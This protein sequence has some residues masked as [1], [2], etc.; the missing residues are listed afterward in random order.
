[1]GAIINVE[2]F[3]IVAKRF[4]PPNAWTYYFS[5][6]DDE[7]S[8]ELNRK[9]FQRVYLRPR[10]LRSVE[11][12]DTR[13]TILGQKSSLPIFVSSAAMAKFAH[14]NGECTIAS[15][16]SK[17][18]VIQVVSTS[19]SMSIED[20]M[21]ARVS[22]EQPVFFQLYVNRDMDKSKALIRRAEKAGVKAIWI[23]VD[24]PVIG[25][26]KKDE[27]LK[28]EVNVGAV[29]RSDLGLSQVGENSGGISQ[30]QQVA[31]IARTMS[32]IITPRLNWEDLSWIRET[33][34]LPLVIKGIQCVEDALLAF[35]HL[36]QGIVL[37]NH[38]GRS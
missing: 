33:T 13:T 30:G 5:G 26:R 20:I 25:K 31:S 28:A 35:E 8:K 19:S 36:M 4:L 12:I 10:I 14:L 22:N 2:D 29:G 37:S 27:R 15:G 23:T 24:L 32:A 9:A 18:G 7:I 16:V 11:V 34:S 3:E 1:L 17:E 21:E 6:A 38:G